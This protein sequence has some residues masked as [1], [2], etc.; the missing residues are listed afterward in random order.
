MG[1]IGLVLKNSLPLHRSQTANRHPL[2]LNT[3]VTST[4]GESVGVTPREGGG[5]LLI[6]HI[7]C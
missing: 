3:R 4:Q 5:N 6:L 7:E 2:T 1:K